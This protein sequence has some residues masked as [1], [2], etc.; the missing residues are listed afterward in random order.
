MAKILFYISSLNRGG[1]ERVL[2]SVMDF[3]KD[4]HEILLLT[5]IYAE[6]EYPLPDCIK[7]ICLA[8]GNTKNRNRIS[9][10]CN[11]IVAIR[12]VCKKEKVE[13]A[14]AFM[15]SSGIR[16]E[17]ATYFM[18]I[19]TAI[20]I[21]NNPS[22]ELADKK[23]RKLLLASLKQ[24]NGVIF[25]MES[26]KE[27]FDKEI[28]EKAAVIYNPANEQFCRAE[29]TG[30]RKDKIV[31]VGRLFDYKN[32]GLLIDSFSD[33]KKT[34]PNMKLYIYG[35]G[36]YREALEKQIQKLNLQEDVF[37]PGAI[38]DVAD[39]IE[40]AR[41]FVLPSDTEGMPNTLM[42][43]MMLGL[44]VISTDCPCGGPR[45]LIENG[46]NGLLVPVGDRNALTMAMEK[47]LG[48]EA[49]ASRIGQNAKN[50]RNLCD[51]AVIRK[52]WLNYI[53]QL[54]DNCTE[55]EDMIE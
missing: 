32:Q 3:C 43:A 34:F 36:E 16:L 25:Q 39:K 11:R 1:A 10:A 24:A 53:H 47:I 22:D 5:D 30:E 18:K 17:M 49:F 54:L 4:E 37:L 26:Q 42:E 2:L 14:I 52:E 8:D 51:R 33:M 44:P 48:D 41:M 21:R 28:Q 55:N 13:L 20:A 6:D 46:K 15:S 27:L 38:S 35:E 12:R 40:D 29:F 50:I 31:T 9:A 7:R 23:R 19:K 45:T